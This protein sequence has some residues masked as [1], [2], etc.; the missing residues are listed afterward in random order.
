MFNYIKGVILFILL[1]ISSQ[2]GSNIM[3]FKYDVMTVFLN[4]GI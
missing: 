2:V 1:L 3:K 4:S